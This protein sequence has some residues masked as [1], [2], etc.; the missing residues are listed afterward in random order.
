MSRKSNPVKYSKSFL[1]CPVADK[2][3]LWIAEFNKY[4][5]TVP[6]VD[7]I[8]QMI[9]GGK[10]DKQII[11][12]CSN[13]LGFDSET[14]DRF[15]IQVKNRLEK[16][17]IP[18]NDLLFKSQFIA[19]NIPVKF[20]YKHFCKINGLV[21][22]IEYETAELEN[23]IHPKFEHL[24]ISDST[25][26]NHHFKLFTVE[27]EMILDV[28]GKIMGN[29]KKGL[30]HFM[31]GKVSMQILQKITNTKETDW[32]AVFH[33]A[34]VSFQNKGIL[35]LGDSG[36]GKSTLSAILMAN[37]FNVLADDFLP[38]KSKTAQLCSFPVA[39]SVKKYAIDLLAPQFP[40]LKK[41]RE[42]EYPEI[43]KTVRYLSNSF[44]NSEKANKAKCIALVFIKY[45]QGSKLEVFDLPKDIAFQKLVP[46]SWISP[47]KENAKLFL[48]WFDKLPCWQIKYSDNKA[49]VETVKKIFADELTPV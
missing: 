27:D 35:F 13:K 21:F 1:S 11:K 29:W 10:T 16:E 31:S 15:L 33:A 2:K 48:N 28:D 45:E 20:D 4:L 3:A 23:Y 17:L 42:F 26:Y 12:Y 41:A 36:N 49:M 8:I 38:V 6:P 46:D 19:G 24:E 9:L 18:N 44:A 34:G 43:N 39:I 30:D 40:E 14:S 32:M 5:L 47:E 7:E 37:G 22:L 25:L